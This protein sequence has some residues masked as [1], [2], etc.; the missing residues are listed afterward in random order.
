[1]ASVKPPQRALVKHFVSIADKVP[2]PMIVY[3]CPGRTGQLSKNA[4]N[5]LKSI[6]IISLLIYT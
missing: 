1:M 3:N 5:F 2:L 4:Y 6:Y